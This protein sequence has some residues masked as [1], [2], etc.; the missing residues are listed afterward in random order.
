ML[1]VPSYQRAK[2]LGPALL[3]TVKA[4]VPVPISTGVRPAL[5]AYA[6]DGRPLHWNAGRTAV[7]FDSTNEEYH[8]D[9]GAVSSTGLKVLLK[10]P[11]HFRTYQCGPRPKELDSQ[12]IG[13]AVHAAVL[14][15][16]RFKTDYVVWPSRRGASGWK[17]FAAAN[18]A[19]VIL[20]RGEYDQ[21]VSCAKS[22]L[23][24]EALQDQQGSIFTVEDLIAHGTCERNLYWV[25][26]ATGITCR[27][28]ADL[29][30]QGVTADLKTVDDAR[31]E[32]FAWQCVRHDYDVQAAFYLRGRKAFD[33]SANSFPFIF[34]AAELNAPHCAVVH[35]AD[36][37]AFIEHGDKRVS[38]ALALLKS[39]QSASSFPGYQ[40]PRTT[41]KLPL[42]ARYPRGLDI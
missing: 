40:R 1:G 3:G 34:I 7:M 17:A 24:T 13:T 8:S 23:A 37:E 9:R 20:T 31:P 29:M 38:E 41:L 25:D 28:R 2:P 12:R 21:V 32:R 18:A 14:E 5:P 4:P 19:K 10:S 39:C 33:P 26:E 15:P 27:M 35:T 36:E 16:Q 22:I 30:I 6:L 11:A 42:S